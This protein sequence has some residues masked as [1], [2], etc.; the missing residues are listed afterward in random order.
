MKKPISQS[1]LLLRFYIRDGW[2]LDELK[3]V[4]IKGEPKLHPRS[5]HDP[6]F[7]FDVGSRYDSKRLAEIGFIHRD[8]LDLFPERKPLSDIEIIEHMNWN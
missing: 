1:N 2:T 6:Y 8:I 3:A 7:I 5:E 4:A